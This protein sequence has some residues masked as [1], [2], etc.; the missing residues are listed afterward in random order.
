MNFYSPFQQPC[1]ILTVNAYRQT[2]PSFGCPNFASCPDGMWFWQGRKVDHFFYRKSGG[3]KND[4]ISE[5]LL[6]PAHRCVESSAAMAQRQGWLL[7]MTDWK[8]FVS[9][10]SDLCYQHHWPVG[11]ESQGGRKA[12][13]SFYSYVLFSWLNYG[14]FS[15]NLEIHELLLLSEGQDLYNRAR[16]VSCSRPVLKAEGRGRTVTPYTI[17]QPRS[18]ERIN[19]SLPLLKLL[20]APAEKLIGSSVW[21]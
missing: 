16:R 8:R 11:G 19:F 1:A 3:D 9:F 17:I 5:Q 6:F 10:C 21:V 14:C 15:Q 12:M 20:C 4:W 7:L 13:L 2:V 18:C